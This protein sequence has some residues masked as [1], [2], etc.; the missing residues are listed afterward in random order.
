MPSDKTEA[1]PRAGQGP[2]ASLAERERELDALEEAVAGAAAGRPGLI[3]IEGYAGMGKTRLLAEGARLAR[4]ERVRV[5]VA[6]GSELEQELAFGVVRQLF[7]QVVVGN[8]ESLAG[9]AAAAREVFEAPPTTADA[10]D[11]SFAILH[12]LYWVAV[13][14]A[15]DSPLILAVDDFDWCD[16]PSLR[17]FNYLLHRLEDVG[18]T[19]MCTVRPLERRAR[20]ALLSEIV[21]AKSVVALRPRPLSGEASARLV[22]EGL[23]ADADGEFASACH[24]ATGGNPLLL[25]ELIRT[26][27]VERV[28]PDA[29]SVSAVTDLGPRAVSRAV[30]VR[31]AR[32]TVDAAR[33]ARAASVLGESADLSLAAEVAGLRAEDVAAV[34]GELVT[35]E[36]FGDLRDTSF[37]HPLVGAAIYADIPAHERAQA[38]DAAARLLRAR[39]VR[40]GS[41]AVHLVL[42]PARGEDWVCDTLEQAARASLRAGAPASAVRY[43]MRALSEPPP[44]ERRARVLVELGGAEA[45]IDGPSAV[46]HLTEAIELTDEPALRSSAALTLARTLLFTGP[47]SEAVALIHRARTEMEPGSDH[48]LAMEALE[49]MAPVFGAGEPVSLER[50]ERHLPSGASAG[51]KMVAAV[52]ARH[53]GYLGGSADDCARLEL[54]ALEGGDLIAMDSVFLPVT[55]ILVLVRADRD[56]V[57]DGWEALQQDAGV[58]G[59][60][61]AKAATSLWRGYALLRRGELDDAE[62]ALRTSLEEFRLWTPTISRAHH[63]AVVSGVLRERGDLKGARATLEEVGDPGGTSDAARYWL[64]SRAELLIAEERFDEALAVAEEFER[65]FAFLTHPIDTPARSHRAVA[66]YHLGRQEEGLTAAEQALALA[67]Q[68]GAPGTMARALRVLGILERDAGLER[69][70]EAVEVSEGSPARIEHAKALVALGASLRAARLPKDAREPLR[71]GLELADALGADGL[72]AQA[73]YELHAAGAR[74]RTKALTGPEALTP[75]ERRVSERAATG[76]TNRA[77][78]E[79]LFVTTKTV[80]LHLRNAY[81]KLGVSSRLELAG[82]LDEAS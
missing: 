17:Y 76:Q 47:A 30:L 82:K 36:I 49:L 22:S 68:W 70:H 3:V 78:A 7:E 16:E 61:V 53:W 60:L 21:G 77:I 62:S 73:R 25:G 44:A 48:L 56:E 23:G 67:K 69:L 19:L 5:L 37:I 2:R 51:A 11:V 1:V 80:E 9:A 50:L 65:R 35:A 32:L 58:R 20:S 45:M 31:L 39:R 10:E 34:A 55:A 29:G 4:E 75:S 71:R 6:R 79:A 12:G 15:E 18:L 63:A 24:T 54:G 27:E 72:V 26:L 46:E 42:A 13:N 40:A 43:L 59:S 28:Q 57:A 81:R 74:P 14:L 8:G 66:L 33:L 64:D 52:A 41:V 38:H